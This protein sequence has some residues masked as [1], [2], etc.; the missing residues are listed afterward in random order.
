MTVQD[1]SGT[2]TLGS[3][4]CSGADAE[5]DSEVCFQCHHCVKEIGVGRPVYMLRDASYCSSSC[6][7][8]GRSSQYRQ[9]RG[10]FAAD[11]T[12]AG[13]LSRRA[14]L[15]GVESAEW[16][17]QTSASTYSTLSLTPSRST[18][19]PSKSSSSRGGQASGRG[20]GPATSTADGLGTDGGV[21]SWVI[22]K[23]VRKLVNIV[24][25]ASQM[26]RTPSSMLT[27]E[28]L[29]ADRRKLRPSFEKLPGPAARRF[30]PRD[31]P[32]DDRSPRRLAALSSSSLRLPFLGEGGP[33]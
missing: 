13:S 23:A 11:A 33:L 16:G 25:D 6:R 28:Q 9:L 7:R 15:D 5:D 30:R 31:E 27:E 8:K 17:R 32:D 14:V 4:G 19:S 2:T 1:S 29:A 26:V 20:R 10:L 12:A 3:L 22:G 21:F 24:G 18:D